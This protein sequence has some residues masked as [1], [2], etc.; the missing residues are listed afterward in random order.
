[1]IDGSIH[2]DD[3]ITGNGPTF[4]ENPFQCPECGSQRSRILR[5]T[6]LTKAVVRPRECVCG[7]HYQTVE[8]VE[9]NE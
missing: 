3:E 2:P 5:K 8:K 1:M 7:N 6:S 4:Y 9:N